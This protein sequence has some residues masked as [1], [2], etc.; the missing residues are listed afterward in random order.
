MKAED[1]ILARLEALDGD[2]PLPDDD[3]DDVG[4]DFESPPPVLFVPPPEKRRGGRPKGAKNK[5]K[6]IEKVLQS[7][8]LPEPEPALADL[9]PP[10]APRKHVKAPVT[11][12]E[13]QTQWY[14]AL[15]NDDEVPIKE[16]REAMRE[17]ADLHGLKKA[18]DFGNMQAKSTEELQKL[19]CEVLEIWKVA[20]VL[21]V[22]SH[23]GPGTYLQN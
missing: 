5:P 16:K 4:D 7:E 8:P 19:L 23:G 18:K 13:G 1:D 17:L 6:P 9:P 3:D 10:P 15:L 12:L 2:L 14:M 22:V 20:G 21:E 11:T